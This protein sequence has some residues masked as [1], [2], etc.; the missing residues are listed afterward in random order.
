[1]AI[2]NALKDAKLSP[3]DVGL[4]I[5]NG[6]GIASHDRAELAGIR[7]ALG[8]WVQKIPMSPM[9]GQIGSLAAGSGVEVA[10][11]VLALHHGKIP[12]AVNT[13]KMIDG[14]KLNVATKTRE[15]KMDVALTSVYSLGGQNAA[16]VFRKVAL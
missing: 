16:L 11:A 1:M 13:R 10:G 8:D 6:L 5:P 3:S 2:G 4:L 9:K 12:P 14:A 15:A 7:A